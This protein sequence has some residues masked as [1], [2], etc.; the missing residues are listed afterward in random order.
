MPPLLLALSESLVSVLAIVELVE[1]PVDLRSLVG[2]GLK[3]ARV[4]Y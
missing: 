1:T 2:F 3:T 4:E